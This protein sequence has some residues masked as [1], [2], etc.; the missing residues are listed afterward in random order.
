VPQEFELERVGGRHSPAM[1][2]RIVA[3]THCDLEQALRRFDGDVHQVAESMDLRPRAVYLKL[4][5]FGIDP[6]AYR[7]A[8]PGKVKRRPF[9]DRP[10]PA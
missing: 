3:A 7:S 10:L 9:R 5:E 4:S 1:D 8:R 2:V 6:A